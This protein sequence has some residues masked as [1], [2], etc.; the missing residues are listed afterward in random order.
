MFLTEGGIWY[1][2]YIMVHYH[3]ESHLDIPLFIEIDNRAAYSHIHT[4][5][6]ADVICQS[7]TRSSPLPLNN[8]SIIVNHHLPLQ[9]DDIAV[10]VD[11]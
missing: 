2:I 5:S 3:T 1:I 10:V 7:I 9:D 6:A 8:I 4:K 11:G